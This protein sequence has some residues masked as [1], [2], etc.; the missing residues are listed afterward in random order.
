MELPPGGSTASS[1]RQD[2]LVHSRTREEAKMKTRA[3][4]P[5]RGASTFTVLVL[6]WAAAALLCEPPRVLA[7][8]DPEPRHADDLDDHLRAVLR[9]A[10]FTGRVE[11]TLPF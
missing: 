10:G 11:S 3:T 6:A 8:D 2:P 4:L 5:A 1:G 7:G 9:A